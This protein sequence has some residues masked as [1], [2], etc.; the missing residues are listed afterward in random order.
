MRIIN[1]KYV[2]IS[3]LV[4]LVLLISMILSSYGE[5]WRHI[6]SNAT[7]ISKEMKNYADQFYFSKYHIWYTSFTYFS[8]LLFLLIPIAVS[9]IYSESYYAKTDMNIIY[10]KGLKRYYSL[11]CFKAIGLLTAI[12]ALPLL[13][14]W[15]LLN[16]LPT[17]N[18]LYIDGVFEPLYYVIPSITIVHDGI[19][20]MA[21]RNPNQFIWY[22][23]IVFSFCG[24]NYG[25]FSFALGSFMRSRILRYLLPIISL[26]IIDFIIGMVIPNFN[27]SILFD[28]FNPASVIG[29][30]YI[31]PFHICLF[32]VTIGLL[33]MHYVKRSKE[34]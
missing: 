2:L 24:I 4:T 16:I 27:N 6:F 12:I 32:V 23:L 28:S 33:L 22:T 20:E 19:R 5:T 21:V 11:K 9:W 29:L 1:K 10:R 30:N 14:Y 26:V 25:L 13:M 17:T 34:G 18:N 31:V 3:T 7:D 15:L 8:L